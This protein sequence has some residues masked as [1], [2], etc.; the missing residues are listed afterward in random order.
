MWIWVT[1]ADAF[2][3][4]NSTMDQ[5]QSTEAIQSVFPAFARKYGNHLPHG[6]HHESRFSSREF[7]II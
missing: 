5:E 3:K 6:V 4:H 2:S 1:L 7:C